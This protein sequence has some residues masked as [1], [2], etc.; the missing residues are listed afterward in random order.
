MTVSSRDPTQVTRSA[1][2]HWGDQPPRT[3]TVDGAGQADGPIDGEAAIV[4]PGE[5]LAPPEADGMSLE[6]ADGPGPAQATARNI[7]PAT[8][9]VAG[10]RRVAI[11]ACIRRASYAVARNR[12]SIGLESARPQ[13]RLAPSMP[14]G[15][16]PSR[17]LNKARP[18]P[19]I[20]G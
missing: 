2:G 20:E 11:F 17:E 13:W 14:T 1:G 16:V 12:A 7:I 9:K 4:D 6:G 8:A 5:P 19:L 3:S 10:N 18:A 15:L